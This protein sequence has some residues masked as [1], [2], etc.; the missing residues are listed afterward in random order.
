MILQQVPI[1]PFFQDRDNAWC[2]SWLVSRM[3]ARELNFNLTYLFP[4]AYAVR[5]VLR[6]SADARDK[7]T[8]KRAA[9]VDPRQTWQEKHTILRIRGTRTHERCK[10]KAS[11]GMSEMRAGS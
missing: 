1:V 11:S 9:A 6:D 10:R 5:R 3:G 4:A 2:D 8:S 7:V